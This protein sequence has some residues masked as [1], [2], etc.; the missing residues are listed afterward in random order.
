MSLEINFTINNKAHSSKDFPTHVMRPWSTF[1]VTSVSERQS[2]V[3]IARDL[4]SS[5][6]KALRNN[7]SRAS[8]SCSDFCRYLYLCLTSLVIIWITIKITDTC[9]CMCNYLHIHRHIKWTT[10]S[11]HWYHQCNMHKDLKQMHTN[12]SNK[13]DEMNN[14]NEIGLKLSINVNKNIYMYMMKWWKILFLDN[15]TW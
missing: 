11:L 1:A 6:L 10:C 13:R 7:T 8:S 12:V 15:L 4:L 2:P 5:V 3:N 9:T 14:A